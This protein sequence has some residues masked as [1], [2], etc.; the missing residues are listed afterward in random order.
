MGI[1]RRIRRIVLGNTDFPQ[2]CDVGLEYPQREISVYLLGDG[3]HYDVTT[4]HS[5]ACAVPF[6]FCIGLSVSEE[7]NLQAGKAYRVEF[8]EYG[9]SNNVLGTIGLTLEAVM[10]FERRWIGL[11]RARTCSN[12]CISSFHLKAHEVLNRYSRSR[13]KSSEIQVSELESRCNAVAFICPRPVVLVSVEDESE[14]NVF[15]MNLLGELGANYFAFALNSKRRPS[16]LIERL[17]RLTISTVPLNKSDVVRS[18]GK[19]HYVEPCFLQ[20]SSVCSQRI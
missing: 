12:Q 11:F 8:R 20:R 13:K 2:A 10:P 7:S 9:G 5:V 6:M 17:R 1:K 14:R 18:L 3:V 4:S 16:A 19:N 15:P